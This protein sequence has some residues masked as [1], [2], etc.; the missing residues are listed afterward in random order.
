MKVS[1]I[2]DDFTGAND[3]G[4]QL[5]KYGLKVITKTYDSKISI[6]SDVEIISTES[7][8]IDKKKAYE[9][10]KKS[11]MELKNSEKFFKK[12]DS[13]L[14]GN[15]KEELKAIQENINKQE[16]ILVIVG[17]PNTNRKIINGKHYIKDIPLHLTEFKNDPYFPIKTN[18]LL[19]YFE[20][21]IIKIN[22]IRSNRQEKLKE[23]IKSIK[24][25]IIIFDTEN[26]N[27]LDI[28]AKTIIELKLDKYIVGSSGI[29]EYLMKY[30]GYK[31]PQIAII[32]GSCNA[33]NIEQIKVLESNNNIEVIDVDFTKKNIDIEKK[34]YKNDILIRSIKNIRDYNKAKEN[35][36]VV[37]ITDIF[38]DISKKIIEENN[39]KNL[40]ISGGEISINILKKMSID[41]LEVIKEIE[42][43]IA[44]LK[45]KEYNIITKPGGFGS[46][47]FYKKAYEFMKSFR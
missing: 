27:D 15:I 3:I 11:F 22:D 23:K 17:F 7:R 1:V 29:M 38:T 45:Y 35:Y 26:N 28:I 30:W 4:I 40:I 34:K 16:K 46:E 13:T 12:I 19:E 42:P 18:D 25:Q 9:R 39:I 31:R 44:Y 5:K 2:A 37:E 36:K 41:Y 24:S 33:K 6:K 47:K 14:R 10:V 43:G 32:S 21:E 20:G 8:N